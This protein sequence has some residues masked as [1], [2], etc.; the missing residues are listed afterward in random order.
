[1][2]IMS[3]IYDSHIFGSIFGNRS[4]TK[5]WSDENRTAK[6]LEIEAALARAQA[7]LGIIPEEAK[8]E[9]VK[10]C[11]VDVIDFDKLREKTEVIGYP[12]LGVVQ[13]IVANCDRNLGEWCRESG[14]A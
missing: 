6:Y 7:G 11:H 5:I 8:D 9:I 14:P 12:V 3:A 4:L 13:Q 1:M 2:F 10:H